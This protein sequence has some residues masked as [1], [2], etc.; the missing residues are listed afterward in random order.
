DVFR[1]QKEFGRKTGTYIYNAIRGID[2]EPVKEREPSIQFSRIVTLKKNSKDFEFLSEALE[3]I[4]KDLHEVVLKNNKLFK[5]IGI[6][7]IQTDLSNKTKSKMLKNPTNNLDELL[8]VS[9]QLLSETLEN[10]ELLVRRLG[11]KVSELS[12]I[13]GQSSITSYF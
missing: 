10:Q 9:E 6:Q 2:N 13:Q 8:R 7:L 12:D 3:R 11:V 1:L 5:S 4:C